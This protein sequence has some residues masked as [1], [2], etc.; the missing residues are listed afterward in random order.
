M[1][2]RYFAEKGV[3]YTDV[4]VTKDRAGLRE[5]V[6]STGQYGVPVIVVGTKVMVGWNADEFERLLVS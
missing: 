5:M 6:V 1:A 2:K 4:D 3:G